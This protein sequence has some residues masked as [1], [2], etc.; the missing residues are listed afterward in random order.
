MVDV[1]GDA[2]PG[3]AIGAPPIEQEHAPAHGFY[4]FGER[5]FL[6]EVEDPRRIDQRGDE[7]R[8]RPAA[9]MIAQAHPVDARAIGQE[10]TR[11][12]A[13]GELIAAQPGEGAARQ[14]GIAFTGLADKLEEQR[15][16][17][18]R[19]LACRFMLQ[20]TVVCY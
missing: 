1:G 20:C 9:A 7:Q 18:R 3:A 15:Q 4:G 5:R 17:A 8:H 6:V 13:L 12:T 11:W 14:C 2:Q 19:A 16:R 10:R